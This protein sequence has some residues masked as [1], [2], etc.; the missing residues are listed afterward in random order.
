MDPLVVLVG[1][2]AVVAVALA[3]LY[4]GVT[5][6]DVYYYAVMHTPL[7]Q[8]LHD[9]ALAKHKATVH[10]RAAVHDAGSFIVKTVAFLEDN[11]VRGGRGAA[12]DQPEP[13]TRRT[14]KRAHPTHKRRRTSL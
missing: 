5:M 7:G 13:P 1:G 4:Y 2:L 10:S 14:P 11:Y 8:M 6:A 9:T 3:R 12:K